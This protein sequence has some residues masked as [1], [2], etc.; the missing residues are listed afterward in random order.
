MDQNNQNMNNNYQQQNNQNMN[1]NYQQQNNQP[2]SNYGQLNNEFQ[3]SNSTFNNQPVNNGYN[4]YNQPVN[5]GYNNYNQPMY[6]QGYMQPQKNNNGVKIAIVI[7]MLAIVAVV[8][9]L[10]A[11]GKFDKKEDTSNSNSNEVS[12]SNSQSNSNSNEI[13]NS[14][15]QSNTNSN[16]IS[17]SNSQNNSNSNINKQT[18]TDLTKLNGSYACNYE[19]VDATATITG[20]KLNLVLTAGDKSMTFNSTIVLNNSIELKYDY[21]KMGYAAYNLY[22]IKDAYA[23]TDGKTE[24]YA[25]TSILG[26]GLDSANNK[27]HLFISDNKTESDVEMTCVRK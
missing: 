14:N 17:N 9:Y 6:N 11:T 12:N 21:R 20:T 13:S 3:N 23:V 27:L 18:I 15:S 24:K 10:F 5:N 16:E 2:V 25:D 26:L 4:N 7:V 1:N 22:N 19:G 8:A